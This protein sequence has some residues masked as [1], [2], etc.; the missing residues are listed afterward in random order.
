MKAIVNEFFIKPVAQMC[1]KACA[2]IREINEKYRVPHIKMKPQVV[3]SLYVL[4][5]YLTIILGIM[6]YKFITLL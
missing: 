4:R 5:A 1:A 3:F 6:L 2:Q